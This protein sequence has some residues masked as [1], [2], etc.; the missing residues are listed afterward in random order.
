MKY[1]ETP[2]SLA[3]ANFAS[4]V[5]QAYDYPSIADALQTYFDNLRDTLQ[6]Y[7]ANEYETRDAEAEFDRLASEQCPGWK[8]D[9]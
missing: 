4:A 6:E 9:E 8:E 2:E 7:G 3:R 1:D 5:D